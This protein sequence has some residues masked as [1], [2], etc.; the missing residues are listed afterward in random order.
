MYVFIFETGFACLCLRIA[1]IKGLR[2][3][4]PAHLFI[5]YECVCVRKYHG[6]LGRSEDNLFSP[7][8][9]QVVRA[10]SKCLYRL[11]HLADF[12]F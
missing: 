3:H 5:Y 9:I 10:G 11:S 7:S 1:G 4:R 8:T 12:A 6:T 2:H